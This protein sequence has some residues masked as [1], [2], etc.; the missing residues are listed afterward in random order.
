[1]LVTI[2]DLLAGDQLN[3]LLRILENASYRDGG[4]TAGRYAR[5]VKR[6]LQAAPQTPELQQAR[7]LISKALLD[8]EC[9]RLWA[10]PRRILPPLFN[11]YDAGMAY[12]EHVDNALLSTANGVLRGDLSVTVFLSPRS[13]YQGGE[14]VIDGAGEELRI[15][16]EQGSAVL[17]PAGTLHRVEP[18]SSGRRLAAVSWVESLV[19]DGEQR[20]TLAEMAELVQRVRL[21]EGGEAQAL[22]LNRLRANLVRMWA[23]P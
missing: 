15:K 12:G 17:Y 2:P 13:D 18:V 19:R 6:N 3:T 21:L 7:E 20:R 10:M 16:G 14:L 8:N 5:P 11:R 1:M 23:V 22:Q 9:F 4:A